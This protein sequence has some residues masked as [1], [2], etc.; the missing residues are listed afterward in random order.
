MPEETQG[1]VKTRRELYDDHPANRGKAV[2][3]GRMVAHKREFLDDYGIDAL[4]LHY[5]S[6]RPVGGVALGL[7]L[8]VHGAAVTLASIAMVDESSIAYAARRLVTV[9]DACDEALEF[10][11]EM[12][13]K[14]REE[15]DE[16]GGAEEE[17][18]GDAED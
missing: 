1:R 14:A 8:S 10:L 13:T 17:A 16:D 3:S 11:R 7:S 2:R 18:E 4:L 9:R 6:E 5:D 15:E 12:A